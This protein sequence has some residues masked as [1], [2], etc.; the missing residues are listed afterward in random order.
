MH[1]DALP[2]VAFRRLA[3][4]LSFLINSRTCNPI[5]LELYKKT[6]E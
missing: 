2:N 4:S 1:A 6:V 5:L 3:Q